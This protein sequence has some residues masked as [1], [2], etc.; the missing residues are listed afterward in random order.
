MCTFCDLMSGAALFKSYARNAEDHGRAAHVQ[1]EDS[2]EEAVE[3][4]GAQNDQNAGKGKLNFYSSSKIAAWKVKGSG[5]RKWYTPKPKLRIEEVE[6]EEQNGK[7]IAGGF[8][9]AN[10]FNEPAKNPWERAIALVTNN[11]EPLLKDRD[12]QD[13]EASANS[14]E[15]QKA[16]TAEY[17]AATKV[18]IRGAQVGAVVKRAQLL[19]KRS[20]LTASMISLR[21]H[22]S[23]MHVA[24]R[25]AHRMNQMQLSRGWSGW[26]DKVQEMNEMKEAIKMAASC[27]K[28]RYVAK[29]N[30]CYRKW[31][32]DYQDAV[33][34]ALIVRATAKTFKGRLLKF[35]LQHWIM[36]KG[37]QERGNEEAME[38]AECFQ[39]LRTR[40]ILQD[41]REATAEVVRQKGTAR[42]VMSR[43]T[44]YLLVISLQHF[45]DVVQGVLEAK[46]AKMKQKAAATMAADM[47]RLRREREAEKKMGAPFKAKLPS[48]VHW[49]WKD[50]LTAGCNA[51]RPFSIQ[52]ADKLENVNKQPKVKLMVKMDAHEAAVPMGQGVHES[53]IFYIARKVMTNVQTQT[54]F[55]IRRVVE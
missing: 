38:A 4:Q 50:H 29:R 25:A 51:W 37:S 34:A 20:R 6:Q 16:K 22:Q 46:A 9:T 28:N 8:L 31:F 12:A 44:S 26:Q 47:A 13:A 32:E 39:E 14:P 40:Y 53:C 35:A 33:E 41:W 11:L 2:D 19:M 42:R 15:R 3:T 55:K 23:I 5:Q 30:A 10:D 49:E 36:I 54:N 1:H 24:R 27:I 21:E 48:G 43:I 17:G 7:Y 52:V 45:R 18:R